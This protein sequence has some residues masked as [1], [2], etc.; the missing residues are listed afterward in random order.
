V[1]F[2]L[3]E[4]EFKATPSKAIRSNPAE[5]KGGALLKKLG[6]SQGR[7]RLSRGRP[8]FRTKEGTASCTGTD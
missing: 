3:L 1:N 7:L 2:T 5:R 4:G 8:F 6:D